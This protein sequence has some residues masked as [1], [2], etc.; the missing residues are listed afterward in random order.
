ML[1]F[2][3]LWEETSKKTSHVA[4]E[5]QR[6]NQI[7]ND[8]EHALCFAACAVNISHSAQCS[9]KK[10]NPSHATCLHFVHLSFLSPLLSPSI[11]AS[12]EWKWKSSS[13]EI[14]LIRHEYKSFVHCIAIANW[15]VSEFALHWCFP[16]APV[17][18]NCRRLGVLWCLL[19]QHFLQT[20]LL[21]QRWAQLVPS[22]LLNF[23]FMPPINDFMLANHFPI[24]WVWLRKFS[25]WPAGTHRVPLPCSV[26]D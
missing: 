9:K 16:K 11:N 18:Y 12:A 17:K 15:V 4:S 3:T 8:K 5:S 7:N 2:F 20:Q 13:F 1:P 26:V 23:Y 6:Q 25:A 21:P 19:Q 10:E 22:W 24:Y 14:K